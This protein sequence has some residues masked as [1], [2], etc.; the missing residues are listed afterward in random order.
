MQLTIIENGSEWKVLSVNDLASEVV[1]S[2]AISNGDFI[3][4]TRNSLVLLR[5]KIG[6]TVSR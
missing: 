3:I 2:P 1:A 4:R 6:S 5:D